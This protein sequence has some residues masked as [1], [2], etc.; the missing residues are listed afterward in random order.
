MSM[1]APTTA[2]AP[3]RSPAEA[4]HRAVILFAYIGLLVSIPIYGFWQAFVP[5]APAWMLGAQLGILLALL[6]LTFIWKMVR[7]LRGFFLIMLVINFISLVLNPLVKGS[8]LWTG[9]FGTNNTSYFVANF[10]ELLWKLLVTLIVIGVLLAMGLQ[11]RDFFLVKGQ[12]DAPAK[13][14]RWLP[15]MKEND[16]WM[17][18]GRGFAIITFLL[19]L[20]GTLLINLPRLGVDN[21]IK[22]IPLFPAALLFAAMN[23]IYEEMVF[24]AAPLSQ[25]VNVVGS[26]HALLMTVVYFGLGHFVGSVPSGAVGVALAAFFAYVLGKAMLETKGIVWPWICHFAAD[27]AVFIFIAVSVTA[28]GTV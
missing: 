9:W 21:L 12:L 22:A 10:S 18:F 28:A 20:S 23:A 3:L 2:E 27:A 8:A 6:A 13:R 14:I 1:I 5:G 7:P 4:Q 19:L 11:R 25:L 15:G 24:R 16:T 17:Q 26:R